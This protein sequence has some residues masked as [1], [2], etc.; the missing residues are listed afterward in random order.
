[1][2]SEQRTVNCPS[3]TIRGIKNL[4]HNG[5][6]KGMGGEIEDTKCRQVFRFV[7][8]NV[9]LL[10]MFRTFVLKI[11]ECLLILHESNL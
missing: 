8:A 6:Y 10:L 2:S 1:M 3:V 7:S 5:L 4:A 9:N 11:E